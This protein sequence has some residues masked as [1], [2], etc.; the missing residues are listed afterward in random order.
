[1]IEIRR[2]ANN[3]RSELKQFVEFRYHLYLDCEYAVPFLHM[4][5]IDT[6]NSDKN[7]SFEC[8]EAEYFMAY[9]DGKPVGRVAAIINHRANEH[10]QDKVV[11][12]G[13]L[14]F[15]DDIRVSRAL[16]KTVE[17]W[18]RERGMEKMVGPMGFTDMDRE[19]MLVEGFNELATMYAN[20]NYAYYP[21]HMEQM[22]FAKDNDYLEYRIK[23]PDVVPEKFGKLA[24]MVEKRYNLHVRKVTRRE[25]LHEG[26]GKKFF[27][28][29]NA[30]YNELYGYSGLSDG[31]I[32]QL[33]NFYIKIAD[34]NLVTAVEDWNDDHKFVGFGITFPSFS[35]ALKKCGGKLFPI[36]WWQ[37][38]RTIKWHK[39]DTVDL[40][41]IGVLPEYRSKGVNSLIFNDLIRQF[42][43]YGFKWAEAMVQMETNTNVQSQWQY[44]ESRQHKRHR[45]YRKELQHVKKQRKRKDN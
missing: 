4:D 29:V 23:V 32:D 13:W 30:T 21:K 37:L 2:I 15:I 20:Y 8:C 27:D 14:D 6:L 45:C 5:E 16:L 25:L 34:L 17:K 7:K 31:Q 42:Q 41:L 33:V 24:E 39:T 36:G 26:Y 10:W 18:G 11:R 19:G 44:L 3:N 43:H 28:I 1:M 12:F 35:I 38:L 22:G 9:R 40:L